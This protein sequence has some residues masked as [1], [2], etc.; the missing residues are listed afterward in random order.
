[1]KYLKSILSILMLGLLFI[2]FSCQEE[3][4]ETI[5]EE[6]EDAFTA[7]S[8]I[9]IGLRDV[10]T[11]DGSIDNIIDTASC[12]NVILP[13]NVTVNGAEINVTTEDDFQV[14]EAIIDEFEDDEDSIA[15]VFP[16]TITLSDFTEVS[17][18]TQDQLDEF[19][20]TCGEDNSQDDDIESLDIQYPISVQTFDANNN[21]LDTMIITSDEALYGFINGLNGNVFVEIQF[22]ITV[23]LSDNTILEI[24]NLAELLSAIQNARNEDF[25]EDDDNDYNDDDNTNRDEQEITQFLMRCP[26]MV[27]DLAREGNNT[28]NL[29]EDYLFT[30][31]DNNVLIAENET[32][33]SRGTYEI[34]ITDNGPRLAIEMTDLP[35]LENNWRIHQIN[36][37]DG[38]DALDLR[39]GANNRV[40]FIQN[41]NEENNPN[42]PDITEEDLNAALL[43]CFWRGVPN[44]SDDFNLYEFYFNDNQELVVL[45]SEN[46]GV[47]EGTWGTASEGELVLLEID[48]DQPL[49]VF[50]GMWQVTVF[51]DGRIEFVDGENTLV[52][53]Q[54]CEDNNQDM[55]FEDALAFQICDEDD[56]PNDGLTTFNLNDFCENEAYT[57]YET[58][59]DAQTETN[60]ISGEY[61]NVVSPQTLYVRYDIPNSSNVE[62]FTIDVIVENCNPEAG[63]ALVKQGVY[64]EVLSTGSVDPGDLIGYTFT[65]TNVG[66][67]PINNVTVT[68]PLPGIR[69]FNFQGGDTND[70]SVLDLSEIWTYH[71]IYDIT[72][73]NIDDG[74]VENQAVAS[75]QDPIGDQVEDLSDDISPIQDNPTITILPK[76]GLIKTGTIEDVNNNGVIDAGDNILYEFFVT[77]LSSDFENVTVEDPLS[78][79]SPITFISGDENNNGILNANETWNYSAGYTI[80]TGD[81]NNGSVT[82]QAT[83][84]GVDVLSGEVI[85]VDSDDDSFLEGDPTVTE[86]P[87]DNTSTAIAIVKQGVY[88]DLNSNQNAD[89]GDRINYTFTVTNEGAAPLNNIEITDPIINGG[90]PIP[91][92]DSG[93][94]NNNGIL[95]LDETW[96]YTATY[97]IT[98]ADI[99][100]GAVTNQATVSGEDVNG[101]VTDDLSDDDSPLEDDP[102]ITRLPI[103]GLIK[104]GAYRDLDQS[105]SVTV[106]DVIEYE[107]RVANHGQVELGDMVVVDFL[108]DGGNP[109]AGPDSGD[110]NNDLLLGLS[111]EWLYTAT[112]PITAQNINDGGVTNQAFVEGTD[113]YENTIRDD[114]DDNSFDENDATYTEFPSNSGLLTGFVFEDVNGDG[115]QNNGE[116]GI[117]NVEVIIMSNGGNDII[118]TTNSNGEWSAMVAT[119]IAPAEID[120]DET[121]LPN[122]AIL[123]TTGS[124][125]EE[126]F[127]EAGVTI[128]TI[129]DG[130]M[131]M[132]TLSGHLYEDT[133]GNG[134]QDMSEPSFAGVDITITDANGAIQ[135]ILTN[136]NRDWVISLIGGDAIS[137]INLDTLPNGGAN[138]TQ[139]GG[140]NPTTTFVVVGSNTVSDNDAFTPN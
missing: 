126:V 106:G 37:N 52:L 77:S 63:I 5:T 39:L 57:F 76:L 78:G 84:S 59:L 134:I 40:A 96:I 7:N 107:F 36:E 101:N 14:V 24:A 54:E 72:Q 131:T 123:T 95:D 27:E 44:G 111:E 29:Y 62:F 120:V 136:S 66:N 41:C 3:I 26:W 140:T 121:T 71:A 19:I 25:D 79:L 12:F 119:G 33:T 118:A 74:F 115:I 103:L 13:V 35:A 81:L 22:P 60:Q 132:G 97:P 94:T 73:S 49:D 135:T 1:M 129:D 11:N 50:D 58:E 117:P 23:I 125:P 6:N 83:V 43:E 116:L 108:I 2:A 30:F 80:T 45:H 51:E 21:L 68:D 20:D 138:H 70:D 55:C 100:N 15:I 42:N 46:D 93:D 67:L 91:G 8:A 128:E 99:L 61:T 87:S 86:L 88:D 64:V 109:I 104:T 102:T 69:N 82:N 113:P 65:V 4:D 31:A 9:A 34:S 122:G 137:N 90:A 89:L 112:Y 38:V 127:V 130:Y 10:A 18:E 114:S 139:T 48:A 53:E 133:N 17:I 56:N 92:Q 16:V 110:T 47:I 32:Q 98:S 28:N 124:D 75:G 105:N 85:S